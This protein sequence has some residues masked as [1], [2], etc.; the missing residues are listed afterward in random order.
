MKKI[1]L[2]LVIFIL[3]ACR[4]KDYKTLGD[5]PGNP[6]IEFRGVASDIDKGNQWLIVTLEGRWA[7]MEADLDDIA[8]IDEAGLEHINVKYLKNQSVKFIKWFDQFKDM[9]VYSDKKEIWLTDL[10]GADFVS[11]P[12]INIIEDKGVDLREVIKK[13]NSEEK[14]AFVQYQKNTATNNSISTNT[15]KTNYWVNIVGVDKESVTNSKYPG[16]AILRNSQTDRES[17]YR[18][19]Y[20]NGYTIDKWQEFSDKELQLEI[21]KGKIVPLIYNGKPAIDLDE[22]EATKILQAMEWGEE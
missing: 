3:V 8:S 19:T 16:V 9:K 22:E 4:E 12:T 11:N 13:D 20:S 17:I 14:K 7:F 21:E 15:G 10:T 6:N 1:I 5:I 18:F 2:I